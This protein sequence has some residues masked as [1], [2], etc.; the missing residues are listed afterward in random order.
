[1]SSLNLNRRHFSSLL[2][3]SGVALPWIAR[4]QSL[5][6]GQSRA[7][8]VETLRILCGYPPGGSLDIVCRKLAEKM[9]GRYAASAIVD[10]KPGAAGRIAVEELRRAAA[11]GSAML[12][13]P[14]SIIT[15]Y[16][17]V[18]QRL[19]YNVFED[20]APVS[21]VAATNFAF[22][23]GPKVPAAVASFEAFLQWCKR[24]PQAAQC[25][26]AGAGSFPHLMAVLLSRESGVK[27]AHIPYR[28]GLAAAQ[29]TAAGETAAL[30]A[31]ENASR[32]LHQAGKLRVLATT[33]DER[34]VF[35]PQTPTFRE[36][37]LQ[38]LTQ[39]EWFGA[40]MP[41]RT[42]TATLQKAADALRAAL[43]EVDTREVWEK[44]SLVADIAGPSQL[45]TMIRREHDFWGPVVKA[46]GFVPES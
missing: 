25:A 40:F 37:R 24:E 46:S 8:T 13:T 20:L 31:T 6:P 27:L 3:A 32:A 17:H 12:V 26:N 41:A 2:A 16:P 35:F 28:G 43:Q 38:M 22:C 14:A 34:T 5:A 18:Y 39:R 42:P 19:S 15:L 11:D 23:I 21:T 9:T 4:S 45:Q 29:A 33:S 36:L 44:A 7:Q 30:F 1:M 10:N